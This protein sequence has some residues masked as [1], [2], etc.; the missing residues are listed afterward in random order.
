MVCTFFL[1]ID[2]SLV[3]LIIEDTTITCQSESIDKS[4]R[5]PRVPYEH[6]LLKILIDFTPFLGYISK[7]EILKIHTQKKKGLYHD[8]L[9]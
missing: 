3:F 2:K 9:L 4:C 6:T 5:L 1:R 7:Q 8:K